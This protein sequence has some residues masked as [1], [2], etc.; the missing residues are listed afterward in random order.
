MKITTNRYKT[1][2]L[3]LKTSQRAGLRLQLLQLPE[4]S[5]PVTHSI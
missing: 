1:R 2:V 4:D 5:Y 3:K